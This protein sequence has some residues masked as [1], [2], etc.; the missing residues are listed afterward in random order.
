MLKT[1]LISLFYHLSRVERNS[2]IKFVQSPYLQ[3]RR[4]VTDLFKYL[5]H[6]LE[7]QPKQLDKKVV[8]EK[9]YP[10][11][12]YKE[13]TIYD[14]TTFAFQALEE[15]LMLEEFRAN[16]HKNLLEL[17][18]AY[19]NKGLFAYS[20]KTIAKLEQNL[21]K[22]AIKN[23]IYHFQH[24]QLK[25]NA[26]L[27]HHHLQQ[28]RNAPVYLQEVSN[29]LDT[30]YIAE[31]LKQACLMI[32]HQAMYNTNYATGLL[33]FIVSYIQEDP[34]VLKTPAV[35]IYYY[36][37]QL[38][39]QSAETSFFQEFKQLLST[40]IHLFPVQETKDLY[41]LAINFCIKTYNNG[42]EQYLKETFELYQQALDKDILLENGQLSAFAFTNIIGIALKLGQLAWTSDFIETYQHYL[43]SEIKK[44]YVHYSIAKLKFAQQKYSE[45]M[46]LLQQVDSSDLFLNISVKVMLLKIYYELAEYDVLDSFLHSFNV[47]LQRKKLIGYHKENYLNV[48]KLTQKLLTVN[49]FDKE[50][51]AALWQQIQ[52]TPKLS[53]QEW[54]LDQL[55]KL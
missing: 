53:E 16:K 48:I 36:C 15:F 21:E 33:P 14:L 38:L 43:D 28:Q 8:F 55:S 39:T 26:Y 13:R 7:R 32:A 11:K 22:Q 12:S 5:N 49:S 18:N 17:T 4:D 9:V 52:N 46:L 41:L 44:T 25:Y 30:A 27:Q 45:A 40:Y 35:A 54:L 20:K 19:Q 29:S 31:K 1:K 34:K 24:Y 2:F 47:F 37:Y 51:I 50:A 6:F 3:T 42:Q 23:S 10:K